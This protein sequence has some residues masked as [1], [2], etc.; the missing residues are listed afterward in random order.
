MKERVRL[1]GGKFS[2][3]IGAR[4]GHAG[5]GGGPSVRDSSMRRPRILVAD[6]HSIVLAGVRNVIEQ[7]FE[8]V[9]CVGDGKSL[10]EAALKMRPDLVILDIGMPVLNGIDAAKQI[11]KVW[12][13]VKLLFLTMHAN[14]MYLREA[15]RAGGSGYVLKT[16]A[17]EELKPAIQKVLKGQF[18]VSPAMGP[19]VLDAIQTPSGRSPVSTGDPHRPSKGGA[20]I[21]YGGPWQPGDR[22]DSEGVDQDRPI[23]PRPDHAQSSGF[24]QPSNSRRLLVKEGLV[25]E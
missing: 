25:H 15:M 9:G 18:Y 1:A 16:S 17:S 19:D 14:Q 22:Y 2:I 5:T 20:S 21:A 23:P 24:I 12:P 8:L 7:D 11:R 6:D 13:E 4:Q 3:D 10:V